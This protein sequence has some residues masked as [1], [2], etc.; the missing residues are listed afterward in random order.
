MSKEELRLNFAKGLS[1]T[2]ENG[3][4]ADCDYGGCQIS[5][6]Q[7]CS[8]ECYNSCT[9]ICSTGCTSICYAPGNNIIEGS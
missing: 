6:T 2:N 8:S 7:G 1:F 9:D 4:F 5:C 3:V